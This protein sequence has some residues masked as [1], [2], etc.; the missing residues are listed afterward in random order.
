MPGTHRLDRLSAQK[1]SNLARE[2]NDLRAI[3]KTIYRSHTTQKMAL[4]Q[5]QICS[6]PVISRLMNAI[7]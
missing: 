5:T 7:H 1:Q 6:T 3:P 4:E 2:R